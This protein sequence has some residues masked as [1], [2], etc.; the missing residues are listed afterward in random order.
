MGNQLRVPAGMNVFSTSTRNF[1][2]RMGTGARVFLGSAELGAIAA[3]TGELP[4]PAD[5]FARWQ[6]RIEPHR[7]AIYQYLQ[8][9]EMGP[10]DRIYNR[11][12]L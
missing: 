2:D 9:D 12:D 5:Y 1:D 4:T 7:D 10:F 3:L 11:R 6:E 8:L